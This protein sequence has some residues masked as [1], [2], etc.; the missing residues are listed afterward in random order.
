[1][2]GIGMLSTES[3]ELQISD[4]RFLRRAR[5]DL[6]DIARY[7]AERWDEQQAEP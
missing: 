4:Y 1:M 7:T 2:D 6:L 3:G 5:A